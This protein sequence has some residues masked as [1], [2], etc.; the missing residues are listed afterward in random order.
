MSVIVQMRFGSH[1]Y[2]TATPASDLDLKAV[3]IPAA[4]D[5]LLGRVQQVVSR[6]TKLDASAR[7]TA[8][9]VDFESFTL[10]RYLGLVAEGQTVALDMLFA[11]AWALIE[12]PDPLWIEIQQNRHR[13]VTRQYAAFIGYCRAQANKY[14]IKGS[15][16]AASRAALTLLAE[17]TEE[18]GATA[19]LE[20]VS[21]PIERLTAGMEHMGFAD[22][23]MVNGGKVRHWEVC[24]RK[25][26][27]TAS[28]KSAHDTMNRLV[29]EY[30]HR[31]LAAERKEGVDWKSLSHAVRIARQALELLRTGEVQFPRPDAADLLAMKLGERTYA[32]VS[33]EID[34]LIP[35]IEA[36]ALSSSLPD[37]PDLAWIDGFVERVYRRQVSLEAQWVT[38]RAAISAATGQQPQPS[39]NP[40]RDG[41]SHDNP[42]TPTAQEAREG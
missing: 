18:F 20:T 22:Q 8:G 5:I 21:G 13:L 38:R 10:Q 6:K 12:E 41:S 24:G 14:G 27:F 26:P 39:P 31:S 36:A 29:V 40:A 19:K 1:L 42:S 2:G 23:E 34:R 30:G 9:D 25:M 32:S 16:V 35:E 3:H 17:A 28:I 11:P 33:E 37:R 4:R 7:N 15:R